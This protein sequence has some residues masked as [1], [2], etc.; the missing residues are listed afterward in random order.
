M[1]SA[2][3]FRWR[4][5]GMSIQSAT[6]SDVEELDQL[7]D[8]LGFTAALFGTPLQVDMIPLDRPSADPLMLQFVIGD[9]A[10]TSLVWHLDG[11]AF[12][13]VQRGVE[14]PGDPL[15]FAG[16]FGRDSVD[17]EDARLLPE[18]LREMLIATL[19]TAGRPH[20]LDWHE[21]PMD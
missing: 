7:L 10:R 3:H 17:A 21:M 20:G 14:S 9:A 5:P 12:A 2:W 11:Q 8:G 4:P 15:E 18:P 19:L 6:V 13:A 1:A 16:L